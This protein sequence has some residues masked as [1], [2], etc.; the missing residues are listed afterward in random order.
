MFVLLMIWPR[1]FFPFTWTFMVLV[2]APINAWLGH[3]SLFDWTKK[4]DWRPFVSLGLGVL[5][6]GFFWE[7]WNYFSFPK[8]V[9]SVPYLGGLPLF[10]MPLAGYLGYIPF[11]LEL[12]S[13]VYLVLGLMGSPAAAQITAGLDPDSPAL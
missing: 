9:Y 3:R 10:E 7:M 2:L 4:G 5:V 8:W 12:V 6:C 1:L 13:V 11:A